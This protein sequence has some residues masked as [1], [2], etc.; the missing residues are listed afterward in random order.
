MNVVNGGLKMPASGQL[1]L[2]TLEQLSKAVQIRAGMDAEEADK[3]SEMVLSYFGFEVQVIDN[4]L[5][6]EDRRIFYM[7]HDLGLLSSD[8][9]ETLIPSGRMWRIYYWQLNVG[10]IR[11]VISKKG[12]LQEQANVYDKLPTEAWEH[13]H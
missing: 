9:E 11:S 3:I 5:D 7:L 4:S 6:P 12:N 8:W 2:V 1:D 10:S 13:E